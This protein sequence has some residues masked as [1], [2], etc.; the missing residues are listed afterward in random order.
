MVRYGKN[1][2]DV[3]AG[4]VRLARACTNKEII[5]C[6]GYHD[7]RIGLLDQQIETLVFQ[8]MYVN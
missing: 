4:A 8:R 6:C 2:S 1:G 7:G 5:A 3:T